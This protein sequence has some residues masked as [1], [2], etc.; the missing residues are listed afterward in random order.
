MGQQFSEISEGQQRFIKE[1]KLFFVGTAAAEGR[2]N[3]SPK[4]M[5]SLYVMNKNRVI[6]L[7]VT[8]SG[9]ETAAHVQQNKRMT[10]MFAA[11]EGRP[12]IMRLYGSARVIHR[13]DA[14]WEKLLPY[15]EPLP[16]AR[17]IF[18]LEVDLV[19]TS[20]GVAVPLFDYVDEREALNDWA[21]QKGETG[22]KQ[23]WSDNNQLSLDGEATNIVSKSS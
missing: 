6:W 7:N 9:N 4:G 17:Q 20:C 8:G 3:V 1:Q 12:L 19:Q 10:I 18:D 16:G 23:Y 15:F 21:A 22:I 11:F 5:E 13:G 2:V 14:D